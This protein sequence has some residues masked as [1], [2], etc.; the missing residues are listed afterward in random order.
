MRRLILF[1][2]A[3]AMLAACGKDVSNVCQDG[4]KQV[5]FELEGNWGSPVFTRAALSADGYDM[6][7]L[8]VFDYVDGVLAQ[9]LHQNSTDA[10]F[11]L[12]A[13]TLSYGEHRLYFVV[14]RG[15]SP[16][17]D[18]TVIKWD[19]PRDTFWKSMSLTVGGGSATSYQVAMERV[20]TKLRIVVNDAVPDDAAAVAMMPGRWYY[21]L[22]YM[23]GQPADLRDGEDRIVSI[24]ASYA[25]TAGQLSVSIFGFSGST[26]WTTPLTVTV[27]DANNDI[28]GMVEIA[29]APFMANRVTEYAGSLFSTGGT[30]SISLNDEW[31]EPWTGGW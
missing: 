6:T 25:G 27:R 21:G 14:S 18:G 5:K 26:E 22:D 2:I 23:T 7:D 30:F 28:I 15:L 29:A 4:S 16:M 3:A 12:P 19:S 13:M 1:L 10:D 8:W 20:V 11:G 9:T 17:L 24:P 31:D